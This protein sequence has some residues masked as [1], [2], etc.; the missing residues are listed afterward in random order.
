MKNITFILL[1]MCFT[2]GLAPVFPGPHIWGKLKWVLGGAH[3]MT[4]MDW[5]DFIM[6][7]TPWVLLLGY[8]SYKGIVYLNRY[9]H[10]NG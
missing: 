4:K 9:K 6:H 10:K 7:G 8:L 5:F 1:A 3:G 2:L